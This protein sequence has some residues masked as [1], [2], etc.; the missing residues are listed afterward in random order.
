MASYIFMGIAVIGGI[1]AL[2]GL[3][4]HLRSQFE[5]D[6]TAVK[7]DGGRYG[8][9]FPMAPLEKRAWWGLGIGV[10]MLAAMVVE[11][12]A[13]G[14]STF[15]HDKQL[16]LTVTAIFLAGVTAYGILLMTARRKIRKGVVIE[17][18]RDRMIMRRA[19]SVRFVTVFISLAVWAIGLTEFYWDQQAIPIAYPY[20]IF[21]SIFIVNVVAGSITSVIGYRRL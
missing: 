15:Q 1:L 13:D 18:E 6:Q 19:T 3:I 11:S 2:M 12:T 20:L 14:A 21:W 7:G 5:P 17:D 4:K 10:V 8:T 9:R 16:R